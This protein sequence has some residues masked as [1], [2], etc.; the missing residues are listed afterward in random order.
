MKIEYNL[1]T[2]VEAVFKY[3]PI[4]S[5]SVSTEGRLNL[6][7]LVLIGAVFEQKDPFATDKKEYPLLRLLFN[8][9]ESPSAEQRAMILFAC[10]QFTKYVGPMCVNNYLLPQC[11]EQINHKSEERRMLVAEACAVLAP[12]IYTEMRS[13]L[14]FSILKEVIE[15]EKSEQVRVSAAKSLAILI[16]YI[17]DEQKFNQVSGQ[18]NEH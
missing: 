9:I 3:L 14:M 12:H 8:L 1:S 4:V 7:P 2:L 18:S 13:S 6:L 10:I 17:K 5:P 11:W 15:Q 16:N